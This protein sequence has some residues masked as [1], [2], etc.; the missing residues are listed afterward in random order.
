MKPSFKDWLFAISFGLMMV[1]TILLVS[2]TIVFVVLSVSGCAPPIA[3]PHPKPQ[4]P[5]TVKP[6]K[7]E[8]L[9]NFPYTK[10]DLYVKQ[11]YS[12]GKPI[13]DKATIQLNRDLER[14][15]ELQDDLDATGLL[16]D[17]HDKSLPDINT[18]EFMGMS[19]AAQRAALLKWK[20]DRDVLEQKCLELFAKL[21]VI[22]RRL[23]KY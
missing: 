11:P 8:P 6:E 7:A 1:L 18:P 20:A 9:E 13:E 5:L 22:K 15:R 16:L 12:D 23:E 19:I 21:K 10:D 4:P 14:V 3:Q 17:Q 2:A